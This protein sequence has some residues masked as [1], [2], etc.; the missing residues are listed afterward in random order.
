MTDFNAKQVYDYFTGNK[1]ALVL[2]TFEFYFKVSFV[3]KTRTGQIEHCFANFG[4]LQVNNF[5]N[6]RMLI[7]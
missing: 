7:K 4:P 1:Y 2:N 5:N 6:I 3:R